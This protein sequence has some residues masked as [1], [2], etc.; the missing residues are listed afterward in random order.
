MAP[1]VNRQL[2]ARACRE[3]DADPLAGYLRETS[4]LPGPRAN[5]AAAAAVASALGEAD[6]AWA[7]ATIDAWLGLGPGEVGGNEPAVMLPFTAAQAAGAVWSVC[8]G[9]D[10]AHLE[11]V[12]RRSANDARWRVREGAVL[13]LQRLGLENVEA[14][15][16]LVEAWRPSAG[17]LEH[18]AI[19]A[20]LAEPALLTTADQASYALS[21]CRRAVAV[22]LALPVSDRRAADARTLRQALGYALSVILAG[23]PRGFAELERL[24]G[25]RDPDAEWIVRSNLTKARI[26]RRY[27]EECQR[28]AEISRR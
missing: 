16:R 20:G 8:G 2:I 1:A 28:V 24:A 22:L 25:I 13:G 4:G 3:A 7:I 18:R 26:S 15:R 14:L 23:D 12:L 11:A 17:P 5:L 6:P 10:R 19:V 27:P 21:W 9:R